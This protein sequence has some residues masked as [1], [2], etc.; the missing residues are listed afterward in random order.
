MG[1]L[2]V[3][4]GG[5]GDVITAC[6]LASALHLADATEPPVVLSY[7]WD[8]LLIDPLPGP[9]RPQDFVGLREWR[10]NVLEV[11]PTSAAISPAGSSL[12]QLA[13]E[14]PARLLL[15]DPSGG[16][17]GMAAQVSAAAHWSGADEIVLVD[18]GGDVL[19]MGAETNLRSPLA[20]LLALAA[21]ALVARPLRLL[22][23]APGIDGE[24]DRVTLTARL[25]EL[26][27]ERVATLGADVVKP[28]EHVFTWHPSEAS[29][30]LAAAARGVR[31]FVEVRDAANLIQLTDATTAVFSLDGHATALVSPAMHLLTTST[32]EE[33]ERV[34]RQTTGVSEIYH[35]TAKAARLRDRALSLP[36]P[37]DL[38][39]V[40][41]HAIEAA[42]RGAD[43]ITIRR[44]AELLDAR[45]RASLTAFQALMAK[46]R[47]GRYLPPLYSTL[48][49]E[50]EC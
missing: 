50:G 1:A 13:A 31:G 36:M 19:T 44:L 34:V 16:A 14:L 32:F 24:L 38:A 41:Q 30:L 45:S 23:P 33:A 2:I 18:V 46:Y 25:G 26:G 35:E 48:R 9:R 27:A 42:D 8:R 22:V 37:A 39:T 47:P 3:A 40:D 4:A 43:Y 6:V 15:L 29:G 28:I 20:D 12:P 10:D 11:L 7:S 5:G 17:V 49:R 21:C